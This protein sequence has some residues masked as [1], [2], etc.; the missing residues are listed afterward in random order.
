MKKKHIVFAV[1]A[2]VVIAFLLMRNCRG[3]GS[4]Y[5]TFEEKVELTPNESR[6]KGYLS[7]VLEVVD[8][9]YSFNFNG[10]TAVSYNS[11]K[12]KI[13]VKIKSVSKGDANDYGLN[14]RS[15][16]P[17]YLTICDKNGAPVTD[18]TDIASEQTSDGI[19]KDMMSSNSENWISFE[20]T[21]HGG[22]K[23]PET[24]ATFF[25]TSKQI[26]KLEYSSSTSS[27]SSSDT[28]SDNEDTSSSDNKEWDKVLDDYEAYVDKNLKI[29]KKMKNDDLTAIAEYPALMEKAKD[30]E[31]S[32]QSA[33]KSKSLSSKQ[34]NRMMK[35]QTKMLQATQ[36]ME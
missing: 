5:E 24:A 9:T 30:L 12:G 22:K 21:I 10:T 34:I 2:V 25:V 1:I 16:G 7:G 18:F 35:I 36:D 13:Q 3:G 14:D 23:L 26:E 29:I 6:V 8:G 28:D 4:K 19:L 27:S 31:E 15:S 33:Q 11:G 17:L 32:L 20:V